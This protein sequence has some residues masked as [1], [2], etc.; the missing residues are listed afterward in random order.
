[1]SK[2]FVQTLAAGGCALAL[3]AGSQV[4]RAENVATGEALAGST[5]VSGV[6]KIGQVHD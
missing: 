1:M 2:I 6:G 4:A 3:L 5:D